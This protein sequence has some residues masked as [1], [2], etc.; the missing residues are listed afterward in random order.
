LFLELY[1]YI[2]WKSRYIFWIELFSKNH[3]LLVWNL[4]LYSEL[5]PATSPF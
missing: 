3:T 1:I 5:R 4:K 2:F